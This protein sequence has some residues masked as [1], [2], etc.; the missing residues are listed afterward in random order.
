MGTLHLFLSRWKMALWEIGSWNCRL[1]VW[2][3]RISW[4]P[5]QKVCLK[6]NESWFDL[7]Q[8]ELWNKSQAEFTSSYDTRL[9]E[10]TRQV[11]FHTALI[12]LAGGFMRFPAA[13]I[14]APRELPDGLVPRVRI[15]CKTC[16]IYRKS[17]QRTKPLSFPPQF[18]FFQTAQQNQ[19]KPLSGPWDFF[20]RFPGCTVDVFVE[21]LDCGQAEQNEQNR[22]NAQSF[23]HWHWEHPH[24]K[25]AMVLVLEW[26]EWQRLVSGFLF[27]RLPCIAC[28]MLQSWFSYDVRLFLDANMAEVQAISSSL[29]ANVISWLGDR[30]WLGDWVGKF[31]WEELSRVKTLGFA[32]VWIAMTS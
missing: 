9:H 7:H 30:L 25:M 10:Q 2:E 8:P 23:C 17:L 24:R 11:C 1:V 13:E 15:K 4:S 5:P 18:R 32:N 14:D 26:L 16:K 12:A 19:D 20:F 28:P 31:R 27:E 22:D 21:R 29:V 3:L 6:Q